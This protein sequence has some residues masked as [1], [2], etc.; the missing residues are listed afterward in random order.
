MS[1]VQARRY[2]TTTGLD[3]TGHTTLA[4]DAEDDAWML[5]LIQRNMERGY[6]FWI[7]RRNPLREAQL[8]STAEIRENRHVIMK[9]AS[10]R[11]LLEGG[12]IRLVTDEAQDDEIEVERPAA[13]A[14]E[15]VAHDTIAHRQHRG[16]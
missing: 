8:L 6:T 4:W 5:P 16:G 7:V 11:E 1:E 12:R 15:A 13:T 3:E 2:R 14:E 10:A 9:D